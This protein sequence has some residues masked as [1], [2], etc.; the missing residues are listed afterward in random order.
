MFENSISRQFSELTDPRIERSK[1]HKLLDIVTI[2]LC[3]IICGADNWVEIVTW[4]EAKVGW[5]GQF[6]DLPNGIPSHDTFGDVFGRLDADEFGRCFLAWVQTVQQL[7]KGEVIAIDG[8]RLCGSG[9]KGSGKAAI[10]MVSAWASQNRLV[11]GQLKVDDKSNEITAIPELLNML[12]IT[13]CIVTIDAMGCQKDIAQAIVDAQADYVLAVK[14]NQGRLYED[15]QD[16]FAG[17]TEVAFREVPHDY[18][19]TIDK[20]HGRLEI[21]QCWT[22]DDEQFLA[23]LRTHHDWPQLTTVAFVQRERRLSDKTTTESAFYISSLG[24]D[25]ARILEATRHHWSIENTLHWTLDVAFKEDLNRA[26]LDHSAQNL[27]ILRHMALNLLK[28]ENSLKVGLKAKRLRAGWDEAYLLKIL[29][30]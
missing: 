17:A 7:T 16:L 26:R 19:R 13:D 8:K 18:V 23:Y 22:I 2:A 15:L 27:A 14:K 4:G 28:Q 29:S 20:D 21:R 1:R 9:D 11:L 24:N 30:A 12:D 10:H 25:A 5:L 3:G 6:L